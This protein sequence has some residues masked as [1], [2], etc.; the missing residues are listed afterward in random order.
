MFTLKKPAFCAAL[1]VL[2]LFALAGGISAQTYTITD[3]GTLSGNSVSKASALNNAG[4]ATGTSSSPTAAIAVMF[5][6][7]KTTSISTLGASVSVANGING[8]GEIVGWNSFNSSP[9]FDPQAFLYGNGSMTNINSPSLFPSGTE[10][11]GVNDS[12][13]VVGTGYLTNS[14]FHAFLYNGGKMRDLGPKGA[15]QASAVAINN[16]GEVVGGFYLTSGGAGEFLYSNG[17]MSTLPVPAGSSAV[18]ASAIN[19]DGEIAGAIYFSSG[20]PSHAASYSNGAWSD[21]GAITGALSNTAAAINIGGQVVGT[22]VFRQTQYHPPKPGKHV[23]FLSTSSGLVDLNTLITPGTGFTLTDAVAINDI[24]Q[25]LCDANNAS[26]IEH[27][28]LLSPK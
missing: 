28:V 20:A 22:A 17:K 15:Y 19:D 25:I 3:L 21:L 11:Y 6:G 9:S 1:A 13:A 26:G 2:G 8:L 4:E 12:G 14:S 5:S 16:S 27:A 7:G 18:N 10:A 23:P 24:G